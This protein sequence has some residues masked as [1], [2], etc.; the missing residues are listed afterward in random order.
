MGFYPKARRRNARRVLRCRR[1]RGGS[2]TVER[3]RVHWVQ[4]L[5]VPPFPKW[6]LRGYRNLSCKLF[7]TSS[8]F[9]RI[10]ANLSTVQN[11]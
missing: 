6:N 1:G 4:F 11:Q 5:T 2:S 9:L 7:C 10:D 3:D 8:N